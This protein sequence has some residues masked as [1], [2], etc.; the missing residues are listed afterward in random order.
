[1]PST[2][3]KTERQLNLIA[4]LLDAER[5]QPAS[6]IRD[7]LYADA[8]S[9]EAFKRMFERDKE[10]VRTLGVKVEVVPVNA[11]EDGYVVRRDEVLLPDLDLDPAEHA[12]LMLAA[13]MWGQ[14][15][16]GP[17]SPR[18]AGMKLAAATGEPAPVPWILPH[19][20]LE[21]PHVAALTEAIARR[22]R[23]R[24]RYRPSGATEASERDVEPYGLRFRSAWY[25]HGFDTGRGEPRSFKLDRIEGAVRVRSGRTPDF[26]P[27]D[28]VPVSVVPAAELQ[29]EARVAFSP[30]VA[31]SA[32]RTAGARR[33]GERS[34]GWVELALPA[35]D[36]DRFVR[37]VLGFGD[38]AELVAPP[39]LRK[40][41]IAE[42][43]ARA[44]SR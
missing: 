25:L 27:P 44:K 32:E 3:D 2:V 42:L 13:E 16:L 18:L 20:G 22:K 8:P 35:G 31:W 28:S 37:W 14:G 11:W 26:E 39:A 9:D 23:V 5:P 41:A 36:A 10:D 34:D 12:A 29:I 33:V 15:S 17:A 6:R 1:M 43:K 21:Q 40:L 30:D 4:L 38:D 7:A 24:F 19:I